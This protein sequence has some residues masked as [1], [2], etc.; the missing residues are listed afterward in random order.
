MPYVLAVVVLSLLIFRALRHR[1]E[2]RT[3]GSLESAIARPVDGPRFAR[4][5][6]GRRPVRR[7]RGR[8]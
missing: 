5:P 3:F 7:G 1:K 6:A 8:L 2:A 4:Y